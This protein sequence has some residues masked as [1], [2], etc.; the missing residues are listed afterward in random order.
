[1]LLRKAA[2]LTFLRRTQSKDAR[3][4]RELQRS[5]LVSIVEHAYR[6]VPYYR[7]PFDTAGLRPDQVRDLPDLA[8]LPITRKRYLARVP[9]EHR[10]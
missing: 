10:I 5:A 4:L 3:A 7:E 1:V 2:L 6:T 9:L 8:A